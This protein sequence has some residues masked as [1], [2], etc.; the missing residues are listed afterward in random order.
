MS[1]YHLPLLFLSPFQ[2]TLVPILEE[3]LRKEGRQG[4]LGWSMFGS[5]PL[6]WA[7]SFCQHLASLLHQIPRTQNVVAGRKRLKG[8]RTMGE[9]GNPTS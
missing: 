9:K 5:P 2:D 3:K 8:V 7:D 6:W 4:S 1:Q